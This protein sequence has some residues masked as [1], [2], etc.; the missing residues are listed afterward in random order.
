M[1]S[2][3]HYQKIKQT[4]EGVP[5]DQWG[6]ALDRQD[7]RNGEARDLT[8][9]YGS[10]CFGM[11]DGDNFYCFDAAEVRFDNGDHQIA[12][13]SV[14]NSETGG[15]IQDVGYRILPPDQA[16]AEAQATR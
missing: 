15:F 6:H 10:L 4:I 8:S 16:V 2:D 11:G 7:M 9:P 5:F 12:V 1:S 3:Y 14:V 13:H